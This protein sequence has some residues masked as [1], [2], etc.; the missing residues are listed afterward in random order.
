MN[1]SENILHNLCDLPVTHSHLLEATICQSEVEHIDHDVN[2]V[3]SLNIPKMP[4]NEVLDEVNVI[5]KCNTIKWDAEL[6]S[7]IWRWIVTEKSLGFVLQDLFDERKR[8][9][10]NEIAEKTFES[11]VLSK[12]LQ[13]LGNAMSNLEKNLTM[14]FYET[15]WSCFLNEHVNLSWTYLSNS[16]NVIVL[17]VFIRIYQV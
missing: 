2:T 11:T 13:D 5:K 16:I 10:T 1:Q 8:E 14:L 12:D 6:V 7:T 9:L 15:L 3:Q 17:Q 4:L